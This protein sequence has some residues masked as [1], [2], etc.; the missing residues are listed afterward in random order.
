M[1]C[2]DPN[3]ENCGQLKTDGSGGTGDLARITI[4][5]TD[6]VQG[7]V[8]ESFVFPYTLIN[9]AVLQVY[10][11]LRQIN[12]YTVKRLPKEVSQ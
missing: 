5:R 1:A 8:E 4:L 10:A 3:C 12:G 6:D 7:E 11:A 2:N 9:F